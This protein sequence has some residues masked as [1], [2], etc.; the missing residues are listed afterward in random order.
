[1]SSDIC[2]Y[3]GK[4]FPE[5]S[6]TC[7]WCTSTNKTSVDLAPAFREHDAVLPANEAY[8]HSSNENSMPTRSQTEEPSLAV[9]L[10]TVLGVILG[11]VACYQ[12]WRFA[13]TFGKPS[14]FSSANSSDLVIFWS[15][16]LLW[17]LPEA[18][19]LFKKGSWLG[20]IWAV[21][22]APII[23]NLNAI[24]FFLFFSIA[25][26]FFRNHPSLPEHIGTFLTAATWV[27]IFLYRNAAS[28][29]AK[30]DPES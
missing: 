7:N 28:S 13:L 14:P 18:F 26:Q 23:G 2:Q 17:I 3:C 4:K 15:P 1:M 8:G 27:L 25:N 29:A 21:A 19:R 12:I 22:V 9:A 11:V 30:K 10:G 5:G 20:A 16:I 6:C 24:P